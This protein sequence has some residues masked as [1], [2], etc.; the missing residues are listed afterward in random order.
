MAKKFHVVVWKVVKNE[1]KNGFVEHKSYD[2]ILGVYDSLDAAKKAKE[3]AGLLGYRHC[4]GHGIII[5]SFELGKLY[6]APS[7][8]AD[9]AITKERI[10]VAKEMDELEK[11]SAKEVLKNV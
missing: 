1:M 8:W 11:K 4:D 6:L 5:R 10:R 3:E 7:V 2:R 9:N